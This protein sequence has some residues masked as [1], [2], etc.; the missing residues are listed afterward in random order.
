[1]KMLYLLTKETG[2]RMCSSNEVFYDNLKGL[3]VADII[4]NNC[5]IVEIK[6]ARHYVKNMKHN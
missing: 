1:M 6:A 5:V 4:V 2:F 3:Y